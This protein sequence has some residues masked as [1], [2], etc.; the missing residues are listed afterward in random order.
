MS[1]WFATATDPKG[2]IS[3]CTTRCHHCHAVTCLG[4]GEAPSHSKSRKIHDHYID[5]CCLDGR[6]ITLW[7]ILSKFDT[8]ELDHRAFN[9]Q[10]KSVKGDQKP[11]MGSGI[12][13]ERPDWRNMRAILTG[14]TRCGLKPGEQPAFRLKE[15]DLLQDDFVTWIMDL[16]AF[17]MPAPQT[18]KL[19]EVLP[20]ML[21]LSLIIDKSAELLRNDSLDNVIKRAGVYTATLNL[22]AKLGAHKDLLRL[23]QDGPFSKVYSPGLK[24]ISFDGG[25]GTSRIAHQSL[26]IADEHSDKDQS[27]AERLEN[28]AIQSDIILAVPNSDKKLKEIC[29][30]IREV[31]GMVAS[32]SAACAPSSP[33]KKWEAFHKANSLIFSDTILA[34]FLP[35]YREEAAKTERSLRYGRT[36]G[37]RNK[38]ILNECANMRTSLDDGT[39]VIVAESRPDMMKALTLGPEDSPHAHGVYE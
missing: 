13:Y 36:L 37:D 28:L 16:I 4:C 17:A 33:K 35:Q 26:V 30:L 3:M 12:G 21:E 8:V 25:R 32:D 19:P 39:F 14:P 23:V 1:D 2:H 11:E 34:D 22:V 38:R 7:I 20:A 6:L 9:T 5:Y 15:H 29:K 18:A 24:E 31:Y 10:S 27:L